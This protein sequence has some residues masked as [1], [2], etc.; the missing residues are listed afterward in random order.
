MERLVL[1]AALALVACTKGGAG[2][3]ALG[4][5]V[6]AWQKAGLETSTFAAVDGKAF[7]DATCKAGTIRG[8]AT[9]VCEYKGADDAKRAEAAGLSQ[10]RDATGL[11]LAQGKLLLVLVDRDRKDPNGKTMNE[12]ARTFRNR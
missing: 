9:T 7:G 4:G 10:V 5:A 6:E 8:V 11:A 3:G 2:D 12:I 1:I